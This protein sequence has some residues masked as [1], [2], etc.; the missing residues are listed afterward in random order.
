M[1]RAAQVHCRGC[2][3]VFTPRGLS[4]H[5]SRSRSPICRAA[6]AT[7]QLPVTFQTHAASNLA[8]NP[9]PTSWDHDNEDATGA[10]DQLEDATGAANHEDA[11]RAADQD[12]ARVVDQDAAGAC[13]DSLL[14]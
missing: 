13:G 12:T 4:Q 14:S 9:V 3:R 2:N 8:S 11:A 1:S 5:P 6:H 10:A 7:I